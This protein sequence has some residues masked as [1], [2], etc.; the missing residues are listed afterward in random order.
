MSGRGSGH[1]GADGPNDLAVGGPGVDTLVEALRE[2]GTGRDGI[3]GWLIHVSEM[4]RHSLGVKDRQVGN[5][6]APLSVSEKC[7]AR[8]LMIWSDGRVSRGA[9]ERRQIEADPGETLDFAR[10]VAYEDPDAAHVLG[11]AR[12]PDVELYDPRAAAI[13]AGDTALLATRLDAVRDRA[14]RHHAETWSGAFLA[15]DRRERAL[16]SAGLDVSAAGTSAAWHVTVD[17]QASAGF[18]ARAPEPNSDFERR[19]DRLFDLAER[20][21]EPAESMRPGKLPVLLHP[22]VVE[23]FVLDTILYH[24]DGSTVAH[25]EGRFRREQFGDGRPVLREDLGLRLDPLRPL[26]IGSYRFTAEGWPASHCTYIEGGRL[27]EPLLDVKYAHRLGRR[28]TPL[29]HSN[30]TLHF[31]GATTLELSEALEEATGGAVV[32][33]VLGAHTQDHASGD[34]SLSVQG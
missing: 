2:A 7:S 21:R 10:A 17:G 15:T 23:N 30:D 12:F 4:R 29:P 31:E 20:L 1:G 3:R 5:A 8:Y 16:T 14:I 28:P 26:R 22:R 33:S 25:C 18:N 9:L 13:A 6:H 32:Y 11:P 34:F 27:I 24:L 19:L